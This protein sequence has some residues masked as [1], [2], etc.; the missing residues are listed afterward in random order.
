MSSHDAAV[1]VVR[2]AIAASLGLIVAAIAR[3][4]GRRFVDWWIYGT[5]FFLIALIVILVL[6]RKT[7]EVP[8]RTAGGAPQP[9]IPPPP[10]PPPP[11]VPEP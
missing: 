3:S 9:R 1:L 4:K 6:P 2:L 11:E 10:L 5:F 8:A 7:L